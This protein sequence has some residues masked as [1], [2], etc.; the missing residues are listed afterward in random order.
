MEEKVSTESQKSSETGM[1]RKGSILI[2]LLVLLIASL[3]F[4]FSMNSAI[5][6]IFDFRYVDMIK[7]IFNLIVIGAVLYIIKIFVLNK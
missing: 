1:F 3:G 4:Y 6:V 2:L 5:N 7:S